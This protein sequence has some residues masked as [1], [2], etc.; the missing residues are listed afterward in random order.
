MLLAQPVV[1]ISINPGSC[2]FKSAIDCFY[3]IHHLP[4]RGL[5]KQRHCTQ[6]KSLVLKTLVQ[7]IQSEAYIAFHFTGGPIIACEY[8]LTFLS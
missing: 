7:N 6:L 3:F 1:I 2:R 8:R 5:A 4:S